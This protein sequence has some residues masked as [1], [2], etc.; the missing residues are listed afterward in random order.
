[1][2]SRRQFLKGLFTSGVVLG[3]TS[4]DIYSANH[5][6]QWQK[7]KVEKNLNLPKIRILGLGGCGRTVIEYLIQSGL[8]GVE[9]MVADKGPGIT[10]SSLI[11]YLL[12]NSNISKTEN[13]GKA[14]YLSTFL[15][16][17][18]KIRRALEGSDMVF[19][20]AGMGGETGTFW[21]PIIAEVCNGLEIL[22]MAVIT[23]PLYCESFQTRIRAELEVEK[24]SKIADTIIPVDLNDN[25]LLMS[26]DSSFSEAC[27]LANKRILSA[28]QDITGLIM[29]PGLIDLDFKDVKT[30]F[31]QEGLA[32][33]ATGVASGE[34]RARQAAHKAF[35]ELVYKGLKLKSYQQLVVSLTVGPDATHRELAEAIEVIRRESQ[36]KCTILW[37]SSLDRTMGGE[38]RATV[39]VSGIAYKRPFWS[40]NI[41]FQAKNRKLLDA[42]ENLAEEMNCTISCGDPSAPDIVATGYFVAI[43]DR[44]LSEGWSWNYFLEYYNATKDDTPLIIVDKLQDLEL[45]DH[46][47]LKFVDLDTPQA[48]EEIKSYICKMG[49]EGFRSNDHL[50]I[51]NLVYSRSTKG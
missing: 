29:F 24:L 22:S 17:R 12:L 16:N 23:T 11:N 42:L 37:G 48:L 46:K 8:T 30:I 45:P 39:I 27:E 40:K 33:F 7:G 6:S 31:S 10:T 19:I 13:R 35:S 38:F 5:L 2:L 15:S 47:N 50:H 44:S 43:I 32:T 21:A 28:V 36:E 9:F 34:G 51:K 3:S 49:P 25:D 4:L 1:M 18:R 26:P 14:D 20:I 41:F